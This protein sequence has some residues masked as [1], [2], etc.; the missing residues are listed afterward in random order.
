MITGDVV[1]LILTNTPF[2]WHPSAWYF[3]GI[4][5]LSALPVALAGLGFRASLAGRTLWTYDFF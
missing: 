3:G 4:V 1:A 5:V 2:A